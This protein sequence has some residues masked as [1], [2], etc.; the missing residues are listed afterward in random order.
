MF[1]AEYAKFDLTSLN[2]GFTKDF[3]IVAER[4]RDRMIKVFFAFNFRDAHG[5]TCISRFYK[6]RKAEFLCDV[7]K[8][9]L[10][11]L[12]RKKGEKIS[13]RDVRIAHYSFHYILIHAYSRT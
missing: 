4:L 10:L 12:M 1:I 11:F 6:E 3:A 8:I 9:Y 13:N 2:I 7:I 5:R